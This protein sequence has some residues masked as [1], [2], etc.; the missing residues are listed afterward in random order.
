MELSW[1]KVLVILSMKVK[2][3]LWYLIEKILKIVDIH[4]GS[5]MLKTARTV[6]LGEIQAR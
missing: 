5:I 3:V 6:C 2:K 4:F 1:K